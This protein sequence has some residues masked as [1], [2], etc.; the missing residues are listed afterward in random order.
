MY[1]DIRI[2]SSLDF[3]IDALGEAPGRVLEVGCGSGL[4]SAA[5]LSRGIE[6]T[7]IDASLSSID[8]ARTAGVPAIHTDFLEFEDQPFNAIVFARSLHHVAQLEKCIDHAAALLLHGGIVVIDEFDCEA[9]SEQT[10]R[11]FFTMK[12]VLR[13][14]SRDSG[15]Q[16]GVNES[17]LPLWEAEHRDIHSWTTIASALLQKFDTI[18]NSECAYLYRYLAQYLEH[19]DQ[20][21]V[22]TEAIYS[23]ESQLI[24]AGLMQACGRQLIARLHAR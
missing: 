24:A 18:R 8:K 21:I 9:M 15:P 22:L 16:T 10:A 5:L 23:L 19:G 7:S 3:I 11:W 14:S 4:L 20:R 12:M 6:V 17:A 1:V 2:R 13:G